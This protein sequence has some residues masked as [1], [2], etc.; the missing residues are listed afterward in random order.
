[1]LSSRCSSDLVPGIG[2]ITGDFASSQARAT[3]AAVA[4]FFLAMDLILSDFSASP[5][6]SGNHGRKAIPSFS[7]AL[8]TASDA[9]S[10]TLYLFCTETI[11][12]ILRASSSCLTLTLER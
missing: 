3:C 8:S 11:G 10:S 9:R 6:P 12:Q 2:R 5:E 4:L 1:M 7:Q